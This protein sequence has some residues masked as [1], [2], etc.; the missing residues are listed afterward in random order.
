MIKAK[1]ENPATHL[2]KDVAKMKKDVIWERERDLSDSSG[3]AKTMTSDVIRKDEVLC[4]SGDSITLLLDPHF[5]VEWIKLYQSLQVQH[6]NDSIIMFLFRIINVFIRGPC[7]KNG[8][9][10]I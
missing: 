10:I 7:L 9:V 1:T 5:A 4:G 2:A 3:M 8:K 6:K